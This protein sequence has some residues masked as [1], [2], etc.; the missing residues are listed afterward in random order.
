MEK[1]YIKRGAGVLLPLSSLPS[2][3]SI[4]NFGAGA[5]NF[6]DFLADS[7]FTYWQVLPFCMTDEYNSPYKSFS[8]FAGNH[9]FIDLDALYRKNLLTREELD[10]AR[11]TTPYVCEYPRLYKERMT[12]L[13][14]AAERC[15]YRDEVE[16]FIE[17]EPYLLQAC[18][19]LAI[20]DA[21]DNK[22][23]YDWKHENC[24]EARL[25][26]WKFAQYEFFTQ[27]QAVRSYAALRG[28]KIIGDVPIYVSPDSADVWA[29][30]E[31]FLTD[32]KG[33]PAA[34][35]GVPPDYFAADGQLWGNPLYDWERMEK[36][37]FAWWCDRMS[38]QLKMFDGVRL[39]HFRGFESFWSVPSDAK[40]AKEGHWVKGPGLKLT[41]ALKEAAGDKLIIAEDLG[42][43][44]EEVA[45]LRDDSGFPGMR[46]LQF[47][48]LGDRNSPHLPHN[49]INQSVVYTGTHDNNTLLG[50]VWELDEGTRRDMLEYFGYSGDWNACYGKL[51]RSMLASTAGIVIMP[52]QDILG[53]GSD[54]RI[55]RPG[56]AAGNW[57]Y[58]V[59]ADQ[60]A[61]IDK[62][63]YNRL[64]KLY[65]RV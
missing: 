15:D 61:R 50:W 24:D 47:A 21:N 3:Y 14:A 35:A 29:N 63:Y 9:Y 36:D 31:L 38:F 11:Q 12:L 4:G 33:R 48:F 49:Y 1:N 16:K 34:V 56:Q 45:E 20:R 60:L 42:V 27:W 30:R 65:A 37:G 5:R 39:D 58:R 46:V 64:N 19:F 17:S 2:E 54:T 32:E 62:G 10:S 25:F 57:E 7:G 52:L 44:T 28:V 26:A 55:N 51:I 41:K 13:S 18:R 43:I 53:Y 22:S 59:T 40:T 8:A 6:I 23:W